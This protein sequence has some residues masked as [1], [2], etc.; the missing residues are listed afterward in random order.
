MISRQCLFHQVTGCEKNRVDDTC[1]QQCGKSSSITNLKNDSFLIEK[2]EGNYHTI[3][4]QNNFLNTDILNE[5][6]AVFSSLLIDLRD[7]KTESKLLISKS[8]VIQLFE[9]LLDGKADSETKVKEVIQYTTNR[10]YKKG[11]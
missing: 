5:L 9:N 6:P 3:Y 4:N 8:E 1:I 10:Q 7:V 11:I 2:S